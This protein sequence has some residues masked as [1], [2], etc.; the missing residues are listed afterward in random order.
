MLQKNTCRPT[1]LSW[2]KWLGFTI[3]NICFNI[4]RSFHVTLCS[5]FHSVS[6]YLTLLVHI[7]LPSRK[8]F[9]WQ[10]SAEHIC[11]LPS[12][13][14][15]AISKLGITFHR[16]RTFPYQLLNSQLQPRQMRFSLIKKR[17]TAID[18]A[19]QIKGQH[20]CNT[21]LQ[22]LGLTKWL[23]KRTENWV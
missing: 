18:S 3:V 19:F 15:N 10:C 2:K 21:E 7:S 22:R 4:L 14:H 17:I 11:S 8:A 1:F 6:T 16:A 9:K 20:L 12:S 5:W 23:F 13:Q